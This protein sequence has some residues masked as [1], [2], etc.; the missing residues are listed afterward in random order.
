MK[1]PNPEVW[2]VIAG[3][4]KVQTQFIALAGISMAL[5]STLT[6]AVVVDIDA[7]GIAAGGVGALNNAG[8]AGN[9]TSL[10]GNAS[11]TTH[12]RNDGV[13]SVQGIAF[14]NNKFKSANSMAASGISGNQAHTVAAWVWNPAIG[15]EEAII[16]WGHRGGPDGANMGLHQGTHPSFGAVGHW[17]SPDIGF[18]N[19]GA[20]INDTIGRWAHL[21]YVYD[22]SGSQRVFIDGVLSNTESGIS[23]NPHQ[24]FN[25]GS[26]T[27]IYLGSES[28]AG[29]DNNTPIPFSG[30]IAR[31]YVTDTALS[32]TDVAGLFGAQAAQFIPEPSSAVLG[33]LGLLTLLG[34]RRRR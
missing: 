10:I 26:A 1:L 14:A 12:P 19:N 8:T 9:F 11:T 15:N 28:D 7:T 17:G 20:D 29:N 16:S 23:L 25:D 2:T 33:M 34:L 5:S 13:G 27:H 4:M 22:G 21:A 31:W 6:A 30:T 32:D 24:T 18:G 3:L